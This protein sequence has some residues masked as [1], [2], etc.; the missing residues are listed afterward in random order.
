[1]GWGGHIIYWKA[2]QITKL[3]VKDNIGDK[4]DIKIKKYD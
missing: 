4:I 2:N 3:T 1:M